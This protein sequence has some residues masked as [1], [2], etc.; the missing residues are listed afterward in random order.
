MQ[1]AGNYLSELTDGIAESWNRFWF[2]TGSARVLGMTRI[3]VG[4]CAIL[5]LAGYVF[6]LQQWYGSDGIL[7]LDTLRQ[8][9]GS[10]SGTVYRFSYLYLAEVP[11]LAGNPLAL[12]ALHGL[13]M[14]I[15]IA[16]TLG[17]VSRISLPLSVAVILSYVHRGPVLTGVVE[18][19]L[20]M[21]L[22]YLS[23]GYLRLRSDERPMSLDQKLTSK[24]QAAKS[25]YRGVVVNIGLRLLQVHLA[26][27]YLLAGLTKL[28]G[29]NWWIGEAI[30]P[31]MVA[32]ESQWI[33]FTGFARSSLLINLWTYEIV[34]FELLFPVLIWSRLW[35]PLMLGWSVVHWLGLILLMAY[36]DYGLLMIACGFAFFSPARFHSET[37]RAMTRDESGIREE[38]TESNRRSR[39]RKVSHA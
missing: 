35:R 17:I 34:A 21:A 4:C 29:E 13:G 32:S 39:R 20:V 36:P 7:S 31:L 1:R 19:V 8:L 38:R 23:I 10:D 25:D 15:V 37:D 2:S 11:G 12:W 18:P 30:W 33:D 24:K 6:D 28:S 26:F 27:F 3:A 22:L 14:L 9:T 5:Y 16:A